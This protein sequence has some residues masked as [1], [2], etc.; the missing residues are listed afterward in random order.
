MATSKLRPVPSDIPAWGNFPGAP[1]PFRVPNRGS[2]TYED[3]TRGASLTLRRE[4]GTPFAR[5][6]F[7]GSHVATIEYYDDAGSPY[8]GIHGDDGGV[9]GGRSAAL[10]VSGAHRAHRTH[11]WCGSS[12]RVPLT[13]KWTASQ[14]WYL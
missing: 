3:T 10:A 12:G 6:Y 7:T 8:I 13:W 9:P 11:A 5:A 4:D 14:W 2:F 1:P